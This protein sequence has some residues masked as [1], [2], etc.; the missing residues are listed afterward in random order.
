M[1]A[2]GWNRLRPLPNDVY[3]NLI[4]FYYCNL[5][6]GNL[7]NIEYTIDTRVRGKNIVLNPMILSEIIGIANASECIFISKLTQL[8]QYV[9]KKWMNEV[10]AVNEKVGVTQN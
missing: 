6:V 3:N 1:D 8:N 9:S 10:I 2:L 4:R 7:D 5:E